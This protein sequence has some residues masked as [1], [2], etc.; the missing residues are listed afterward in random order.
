MNVVNVDKCKVMHFGA[1]NEKAENKMDE[2]QLAEITE[3]KDLRV[4]ISNNLVDKQ[5]AK[6]AGKG[7]QDTWINKTI[8]YFQKEE[9][10]AQF[11]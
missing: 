5:C 6:A 1:K 11:I 3:E 4:A 2:L 7:S 10:K 8:I 9:D